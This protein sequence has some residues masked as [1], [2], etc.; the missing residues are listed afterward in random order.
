[1]C[2][3]GAY[4]HVRAPTGRRE[5]RN[6]F[7]ARGTSVSQVGSRKQV[8]SQ[9]CTAPRCRPRPDVFSAATS[10]VFSLM[11]DAWTADLARGATTR[12]HLRGRTARTDHDKTVEAEGGARGLE[13]SSSE[14]LRDT[15]TTGTTSSATCCTGISVANSASNCPCATNWQMRQLSAPS[16]RD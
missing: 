6:T 10:G 7:R 11:S 16:R 3:A 5:D 4:H 2:N 9:C 15:G 1:L 12:D 8:R 13:G 14:V